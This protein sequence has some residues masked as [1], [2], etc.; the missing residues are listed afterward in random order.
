MRSRINWVNTR[1]NSTQDILQDEDAIDA[2]K[3]KFP[4]NMENVREI[5]RPIRESIKNLS[6]PKQPLHQK[7]KILQKSQV[8]EGVA[9]GLSTLVPLIVRN[10]LRLKGQEREERQ[11]RY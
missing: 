1:I 9:S 2:L 8:G 7:R 6:D 11:A 10:F 5:W 3:K 4:E